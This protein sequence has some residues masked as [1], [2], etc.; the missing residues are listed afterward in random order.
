MTRADS[1]QFGVNAIGLPARKCSQ[2]VRIKKHYNSLA[3]SITRSITSPTRSRSAVFILPS[4]P[5]YPT[6]SSL[7]R[8]RCHVHFAYG[9]FYE[10]THTGF[11]AERS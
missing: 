10:P 8:A 6:I 4:V 9:S 11:K 7:L 3:F 2:V 1:G 5:S